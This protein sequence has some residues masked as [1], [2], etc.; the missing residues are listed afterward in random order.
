MFRAR[1]SIAGPPSS[2]SQQFRQRSDVGRSLLPLS[3]VAVALVPPIIIA[4]HELKIFCAYPQTKLVNRGCVHSLRPATRNLMIDVERQIGV[5]T[6][7]AF[8]IRQ[9]APVSTGHISFSMDPVADVAIFGRSAI[10]TRSK[11]R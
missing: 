9:M 5:F 1:R 2:R 10:D 8:H 6:P 3:G 7:S 11:I 4:E